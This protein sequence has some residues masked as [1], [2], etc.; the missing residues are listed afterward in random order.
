MN[1][2][3]R[4]YG[5]KHIAKEYSWM[6]SGWI[7]ELLK[8]ET[9]E[10]VRFHVKEILIDLTSPEKSRLESTTDNFDCLEEYCYNRVMCN[11]IE[12][13]D[14]KVY[15]WLLASKDFFAANEAFELC[16]NIQRAIEI[17]KT[18]SIPAESDNDGNSSN[19]GLPF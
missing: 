10:D 5:F 4:N 19:L 7:D 1:T 18:K 13:E 12:L 2:D 14:D 6:T 11:N 17:I 16:Y 3:S 9:D 8:H 15:K